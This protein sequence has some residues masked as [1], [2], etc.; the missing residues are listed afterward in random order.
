M[1]AASHKIPLLIKP[2][3]LLAILA[4]SAC[5][6]RPPISFDP[7]PP[8]GCCSNWR[9][10]HFEEMSAEGVSHTHISL[11]GSSTFDFA[12]GRATFVAYRLPKVKATT[13]E[14]DTYASSD[15]LPLAT[16]FRPRVLFLDAGL[17]EVANNKLNPMARDSKFFRGAYYFATTPI[18]ASAEY[19][20]VYA[21]SSANTDRLVAR[22]ENGSLYGL[23]NAYEGDIS[24]ILK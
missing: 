9:S 20:V 17:K 10:V 24:I 1:T 15:W 12:E 7:P 4:A 16:V 2:L 6:T 8:A 19:I 18:P 23:P 22:S 14:V 3:A 21:A 5:A 13:V 11:N